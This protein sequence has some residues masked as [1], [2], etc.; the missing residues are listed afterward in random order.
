MRGVIRLVSLLKRKPGTTHEEFLRYWR[1]NHGPLIANSSAATY[2][3]RYEQ[4][5]AVWPAEGSGQPEPE[6]DG[7]TIQEFP[8]A[9]AYW[10]HM[11][12]P[13]FPN[14]WEDIQQFLDTD[15]TMTSWVICEEPVIVI[16][17]D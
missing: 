7:V 17:D 8:S 10:A 16:G 11:R 6:Y 1:E 3:T 13:D 5:A 2:V 15:A 4:H 14:M 12:E 9:D